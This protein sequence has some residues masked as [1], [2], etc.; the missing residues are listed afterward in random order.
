M[1]AR[2]VFLIAVFLMTGCA[3]ANLTSYKDPILEQSSYNK[4]LVWCV[5]PGMELKKS[6][7]TKIAE[8]LKQQGVITIVGEDFIP[9]TKGIFD[10]ESLEKIYTERIDAMLAVVPQQGNSSVYTTPVQTTSYP[11]YNAY[12]NVYSQSYSTG[13]QSYSFS[14]RNFVVDLFDFRKNK[15]AWRATAKGSF[16]A[17]AELAL[18]IDDLDSI[19]GALS[20]KVVE[21]LI[22]DK[23]IG[24]ESAKKQI[25]NAQSTIAM[26]KP[27]PSD[28]EKPKK[29]DLYEYTQKIAPMLP[30]TIDK[31]R[32]IISIIGGYNKLTMGL[33][34]V[35]ASVGTMNIKEFLEKE[36]KETTNSCCTTPDI[37][38]LIDGGVL[39]EAN[40]YDK[41]SKFITRVTMSV[42]DCE[43]RQNSNQAQQR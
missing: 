3:T 22:E 24:P 42:K 37:R 29:Y 8:Q 6:A 33:K 35:N 27:E 36:Y 9:P 7:E 21:K 40:Y 34:M 19:M 31:D 16:V 39:F 23:V 32:Q 18:F 13:G 2:G 17:P 14:N 11:A 41:D 1:L 26:T 30:M 28:A 43:N 4:I 12:G 20:T 10:R 38:T 15:I 25:R 5:L